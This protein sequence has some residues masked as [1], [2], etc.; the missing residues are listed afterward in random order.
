MAIAPSANASLS[1]TPTT[2]SRITLFDNTLPSAPSPSPTASDE[3]LP[4]AASSSKAPGRRETLRKAIAHRKYKR[5]TVDPFPSDEHLSVASGE[6]PDH[7]AAGVVER[8]G[9]DEEVVVGGGEEESGSGSGGEGGR[10]RQ[11]SDTGG[12]RPRVDGDAEERRAGRRKKDGKEEKE[13][14]EIDI[15]YENQ[16]G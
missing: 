5:W 6:S 15:L 11:R 10:G 13:V 3:N 8:V 1:T 7:R 9:E 12:N 2:P 16:R 14:A 4:S